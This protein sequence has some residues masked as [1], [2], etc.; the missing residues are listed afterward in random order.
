MVGTP[1]YMAPEQFSGDIEAIGERQ[2]ASCYQ[3]RRQPERALD[4]LLAGIGHARSP[5]IAAD[6]GF[7]SL[8]SHPRWRA[9]T[10]MQKIGAPGP[11]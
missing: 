11:E 2:L 6:T 5:E 4:A 3:A 9:I 8:R 7:A 1:A 10:Q